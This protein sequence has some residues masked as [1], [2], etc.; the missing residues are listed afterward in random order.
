M[1]TNGY[2]NRVGISAGTAFKAGFFAF[3]GAVIAS[4]IF[5]LLF[6]VL[7]GVAALLG[8]HFFNAHHG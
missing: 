1:T 8:V 5:A 3:F 2:S 7:A 4:G 6:T